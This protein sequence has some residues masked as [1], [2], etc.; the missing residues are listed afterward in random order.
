MRKIYANLESD[1]SVSYLARSDSE[2]NR[3][4]MSQETKNDLPENVR[5]WLNTHKI[6][7]NSSLG[8]GIVCGVVE[9]AVHP[10]E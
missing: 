5:N 4:E 9:D 2:L 3:I 1:A 8:E 7:I 6:E 10:A